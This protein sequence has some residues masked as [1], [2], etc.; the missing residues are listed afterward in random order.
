VRLENWPP[1]KLSAISVPRVGC[2]KLLTA[3]MLYMRMVLPDTRG[4]PAG[5][6]WTRC[7]ARVLLYLVRYIRQVWL[8]DDSTDPV[9]D[10]DDFDGNNSNTKRKRKTTNRVTV[11]LLRRTSHE[12]P[13]KYDH[14]TFLVE[15]HTLV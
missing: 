13:R 7:G 3:A 15:L 4:R 14:T 6:C 12:R 9:E 2:W 8:F 1:N 10:D 5:P 11:D